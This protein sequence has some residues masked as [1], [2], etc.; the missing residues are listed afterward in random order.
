M[1]RKFALFA[2][3]LSVFSV[4]LMGCPKAEE[5]AT[6]ATAAAGEK[7]ADAG[8]KMA[9]AGGKMADAAGGKMA[10]AGG[11]MADAAKGAV[12]GAIDPVAVTKTINAVPG[13]EGVK[14]VKND[15]GDIALTGTVANQDLKTKAEELAK[16]AGIT[17]LMNKITTK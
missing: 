9:D 8:G 11:K 3:T 15:K 7:M 4:V 14:V 12:A 5:A 10:D 1:Y 13:L 16:T 2:V 17:T 6:D